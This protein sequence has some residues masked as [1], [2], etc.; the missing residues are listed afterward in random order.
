MSMLPP[1]INW[2][3]QENRRLEREL[4]DM[5]LLHALDQSEIVRLRR[6]VEAAIEGK[7]NVK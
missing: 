6:M 5:E 7:E 1:E 2:L 3:R 4:K